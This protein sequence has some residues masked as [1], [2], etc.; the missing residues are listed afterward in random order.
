MIRALG[1]SPTRSF[2][3][4]ARTFAALLLVLHWSTPGVLLAAALRGIFTGDSG[5]SSGARAAQP[6]APP[7]LLPRTAATTSAAV[8][9]KRD[10]VKLGGVDQALLAQ[11]TVPAGAHASRTESTLVAP[12]R[13]A[14]RRTFDARAPPDSADA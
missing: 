11:V 6:V 14:A 4:M 12:A 1:G 7:H 9:P 10:A 13:S 5:L 8:K 2:H 3:A